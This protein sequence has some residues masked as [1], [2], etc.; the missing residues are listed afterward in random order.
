MNTLSWISMF[1]LIVFIVPSLVAL[2]VL[3]V[4]MIRVR[5]ENVERLVQRQIDRSRDLEMLLSKLGRVIFSLALGEVINVLAAF[6]L[7]LKVL[8][9]VVDFTIFVV[10]LLSGL[11]VMVMFV[12]SRMF[13]YMITGSSPEQ[14]ILRLVP[15]ATLLLKVFYPGTLLVAK[16]EER[17]KNNF[18]QVSEDQESSKENQNGDGLIY[19]GHEV[20]EHEREMI[21]AILRLEDTTVREIMVPFPDIVAASEDSSVSEVIDLINSE[22]FT[23]IPLFEATKDNIIGMIYAKDLLTLGQPATSSVHLRTI[24]RE[25]FFIPE[26]KKLD[27]LLSE[28]QEKRLHLGIVVDEYGAVSGLV[29]IEDL[30]E[31]IVGEISDEYDS[32]EPEAE[33]V[34]N[35]EI[36]IDAKAP[37]DM[38]DE[39]FSVEMRGDGF[40]T[41]GGLIF[42]DLGKIPV[43]GDRVTTSELTLEVLTTVGRRI[44]KVR[45]WRDAKFNEPNP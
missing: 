30:L 44:R 3:Q 11:L 18:N 42:H 12:L 4:G 43:P 7:C 33:R 14:A 31:E 26:T 29:T 35:D 25:P 15:L 2:S 23:R 20:E 8:N 19:Q 32:Q 13:A 9:D 27:E 10:S 1:L 45:V 38:L 5:G 24:C 28:F 21:R 40:D 39:Y 17:I 6:I 16:L 34:S 41:I 22:G 36:V 37:L